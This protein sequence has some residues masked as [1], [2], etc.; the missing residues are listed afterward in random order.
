MGNMSDKIFRSKELRFGEGLISGYVAC[1]LAILSCLGALA[2]HYPEYL[3]TPELRA[4][5]DVSLLREVLFYS[6]VIAGALGLLNFVRNTNKRMGAVAW[7]FIIAT[8]LMGGH[9]VEVTDFPDDTNYIGLDWFILDLLG[10]T[11][12]FIFIEKL[13]PHRKDQAILREAWKTDLHHFFVNHLIVGFVL[14]I[15]N[16][17]VHGL[18]GW[19]Q[20]DVV[21][22]FILQQPL[23]LQVFLIVLAADLIQY[24]THRFYHEVPLLWRFHAVHHSAKKMDWLAGSRQ[25]ILELIVTRCMVL[26]PIFIL[27]FSKQVI[28][29]YVVIVGLQAVF[30]HANVLVGCNT[31]SLRHN[32]TIGI[33]LLIKLQ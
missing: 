33:T 28:D 16:H 23:L 17:F 14:L 11:I 22:T 27:G 24:I 2:F 19:A 32:F 13:L 25:H 6:L 30:N 4:N 10:S 18:F 31:L 7:V 9:T 26:T 12:I 8:I 20:T 3:T 29:L 21:Q 5:Y 1:M 15:T